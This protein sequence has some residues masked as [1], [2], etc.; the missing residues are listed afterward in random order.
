M[1]KQV[2]GKCANNTQFVTLG[3]GILHT[4]FCDVSTSELHR[5]RQAQVMPEASLCMSVL[6]HVMCIPIFAGCS[7]P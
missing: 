7:L 5:Q 2:K 6:P 3:I 4:L 1:C